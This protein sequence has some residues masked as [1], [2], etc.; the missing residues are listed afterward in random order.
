MQVPPS[1]ARFTVDSLPSGVRVTIPSSRNWLT[2]LFLAAWLGGWYFGASSTLNELLNPTEK[3]QVGF[4]SFWLLGWTLGGLSAIAF[5]LWQLAGSEVIETAP[6]SL[7]RRIQIAGIGITREYDISHVTSLRVSPMDAVS[8]QAARWGSL[9]FG[10]S[11]GLVAFDYGA[12]TVKFGGHVDEAEAKLVV[13]A[14][15]PF[16]PAQKIAL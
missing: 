10:K 16:V 14:L 6:G 11:S 7:S 15:S 12:R 8:A 3:T 4:L 1:S 2:I 13:K 5:V 9:P